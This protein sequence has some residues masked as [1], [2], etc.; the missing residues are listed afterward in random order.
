MWLWFCKFFILRWRGS[1]SRYTRNTPYG[2]TNCL[3]LSWVS[4]HVANFNNRNKMLTA[5]LLKQGYWIT[6]SGK[7][8]HF[9]M[10][11]PLRSGIKI[12]CG[13]Q[14]SSLTRPVGTLNYMVTECVNLEYKKVG[15][16]DF[17]NQFIWIIIRYKR[18]GYKMIVM[19]QTA[20]LVI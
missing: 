5:N 13:T 7:L 20:C 8:F 15:R 3:Y 2:C 18:T 17:S 19:R 1:S 6:N 11:T 4:S 16:N 12:V 9:F 10:S 14:I